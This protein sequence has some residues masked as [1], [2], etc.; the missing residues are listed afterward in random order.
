MNVLPSR[1]VLVFRQAVDMRKQYDGLWALARDV[2]KCNVFD[3]SLFVFV[4]KDAKRLKVL[5]WDGTG[6]CLLCKRLDKGLF[7][8]PWKLEGDGPLHI[9][10]SELALMIEGCQEVGKRRLSPQHWTPHTV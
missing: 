9:S 3:G 6:V 5:Y 1:Q 4:G 7:V 8:R 2:L 10:Q